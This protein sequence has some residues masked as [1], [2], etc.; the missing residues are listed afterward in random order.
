MGY[1]QTSSTSFKATKWLG[2]VT[3]VWV[4]AIS[5]N[6]YTFSNY[7][8]ALKTLMNLTQLELNNLSVAKD[9]GKAFGLLA[10]L[11]SDRL[12]TPVILLIGSIEGLIGY[13]TQWLVV[14]RRIQP[15]SYWQMCIFLCLG[16]NSTTWM[17]TAVLVTCIRN[18]RRNR[19]PVSGILKG[20]VGLSTAIFT[21]LCAALF[22]DDPAKFLIMLAIIPF[23]VCLTAIVFLRET[24]PAATIEEEKEESKYFNLFNV[25]AVIVAVYLLAY[26]FI[27]NPSHVL[28]SVFSLI[29]LVLLAS[30][31]AVPAHAFINSWNL[32]RFKNQEDV[33]RQ[34]QEP[35]LRED[36][37]QE[38][39]QE[40]TAEEAAK[41][42]VER[43]R[44]VEEEKAVE[45]VKRR[46]V[47]GEDHTVFE[48]MSTVDFWILF[49]SFLCGVGTGLAVMNNMGQIG[50][51]LGYADV[52]LFV[53]MT[54][55]WGF[56][57]RI[58]SGTVSEYYIKKAG[59]PRPLWNAASQILMAVGYIL[60]AVALPGS[61]YIGS[62]VVGVCYGVRLAVSVPTASELFGLKY[63][64]LIYNILI[65]NLPLG[66]F[67]FS[68]LLA[69]L[70]YDA[71]ATPTP[72]GGNTCA[73]AHCY[74]L[75]FII[76][77]V[78]CV[79]GFGLDVLLGIRTKKIYTKIY[80]SRRSK[81]LA[82]AS[83]LQ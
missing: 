51:A 61:L 37:T 44:A 14:S 81:K 36:K 15:L 75:V 77:A 66:S 54:S 62:I 4:Q 28:S 24:P 42:V 80:M 12:P 47:I 69:G 53:S 71:Q 3:A 33:E 26:S 21:D 55:I 22:A 58:I 6:N 52:S 29:L 43:T 38:K 30:P 78:A 16:G 83:N 64:G 82:S 74:R 18:F 2:F 23:A 63:F 9:V 46:P 56:F 25:V 41:A 35:L 49:L 65:L 19:G 1:L 34:I 40:K 39:I 10:G 17:N 27:P 76:M 45:V 59:T 11:A 60:M 8:D 79:I 70:L 32:N 7:S 48:A 5:G 57:G 13:G 20:Y 67:L 72:G 68:G 50:L 31:L 73:G